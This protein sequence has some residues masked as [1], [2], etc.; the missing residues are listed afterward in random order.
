MSSKSIVFGSAALVLALAGSASAYTRV[1]TASRAAL[2]V[3]TTL[4]P[5]DLTTLGYLNAPGAPNNGVNSYSQAFIGTGSN[6]TGRLTVEVFGNAPIGSPGLNDVLMVYTFHGDSGRPNG[7]ETFH[8]GVDT[9][10]QIDYAKLDGAIH[11]KISGETSMQAGQA[12]PVVS[13]FNNIGS[14]DT[15]LFDHNP[16]SSSG[17]LVELGGNQ[18][19][20]FVWYVRTTGDVKLN[21]VDVKITDFGSI[22]IRSLALVDNPGQPDLNVPAPGAAALLLGGLGIAAGRRRRA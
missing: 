22:T 8:F 13:L 20:D 18:N 17:S 10:L 6:Y 9:S 5:L 4:N 19:E 2:G 11:G 16:A 21:F 1:D 14:N 7:A 12:D 3:G 15:W